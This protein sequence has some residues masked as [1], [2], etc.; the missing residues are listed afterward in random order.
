[1]V[2]LIKVVRSCLS[3]SDLFTCREMVDVPVSGGCSECIVLQTSWHTIT[4]GDTT[5]VSPVKFPVTPL[6]HCKD[7]CCDV[8]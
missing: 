4:R 7:S 3:F 2:F 5:V 6:D 1:M 8:L